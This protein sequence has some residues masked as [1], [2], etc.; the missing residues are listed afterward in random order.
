MV[1][2]R[3]YFEQDCASRI[4]RRLRFLG[5]RSSSLAVCV[6]NKVS[7]IRRIGRIYAE[8]RSFRRLYNVVSLECADLLSKADKFVGRFSRRVSS[9]LT[10]VTR[11][12]LGSLKITFSCPKMLLASLTGARP[13]VHARSTLY[14]VWK[15][16]TS[17]YDSHL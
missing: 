6:C 3:I 8:A 7:R 14:L 10:C 13:Q 4:L 16:R 1:P 12:T 17:K 15:F 9:S 5:Q 11:L 2:W